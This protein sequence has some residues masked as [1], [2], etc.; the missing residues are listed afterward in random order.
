MDA[1]HEN[2]V[3]NNGKC[4]TSCVCG[5]V[6]RRGGQRGAERPGYV[7]GE[8]VGCVGCACACGELAVGETT[9]AR[10]FSD[11]QVVLASSRLVCPWRFMAA[12]AT[13][14]ASIRLRLRYLELLSHPACEGQF[15]T[16]RM[17]RR[18]VPSC[19]DFLSVMIGAPG[20]RHRPSARGLARG[21]MHD[22]RRWCSRSGGGGA[23]ERSDWRE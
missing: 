23:R 12:S 10:F 6:P 16:P 22:A 7:V 5:R 13:A 11:R 15:A 19:S 3:N 17:L 21:M 9:R 2:D 14:S 18:Q 20:F 4:A 8:F 1:R